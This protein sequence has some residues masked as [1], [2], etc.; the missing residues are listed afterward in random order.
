MADQRVVT[1]EVTGSGGYETAWVTLSGT[2]LR[3]TG[4]VMGLRPEPYW[5]AYELETGH[6]YVTRRLQVTA[7]TAGGT[8]RLDLRRDGGTW[9]ANDKPLPEVAGALDCDL[10]MSPLTN[11]MPV[12]RHQLHSGPGEHTFV[13]AWVSVPDLAVRPSRQTY[14]HVGLT[15]RGARLHYASKGFAGDIEV[16]RDGL[17]LTYPGIGHL[18]HAD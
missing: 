8:R 15:E 3:A 11:T 17:V 4:R 12:L 10:G 9:T 18:L 14:T 5:M 6:G 16:G 1:W 2:G 7:E 13:M